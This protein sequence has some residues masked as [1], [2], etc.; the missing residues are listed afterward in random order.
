MLKWVCVRQSVSIDSFN[1]PKKLDSRYRTILYPQMSFRWRMKRAQLSRL[2][3]LRA[4]PFIT[5]KDTGDYCAILPESSWVRSYAV[6]W[7]LNACAISLQVFRFFF[8]LVLCTLHDPSPSTTSWR[9]RPSP[10]FLLFVLFFQSLFHSRKF[11][12]ILGAY[13]VWQAGF[14]TMTTTP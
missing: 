3:R 10:F 14:L 8:R 4:S 12:K 5:R 11:K 7:G 2:H 6:V 9:R 13:G 1:R